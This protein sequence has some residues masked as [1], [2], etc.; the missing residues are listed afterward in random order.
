MDS[1]KDLVKLD[2]ALQE[3][4]DQGYMESVMLAFDTVDAA[5][6]EIAQANPENFSFSAIYK[7][8]KEKHLL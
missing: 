2:G 5:I 4:S 8:I 7:A 1:Q 6:R 3:L